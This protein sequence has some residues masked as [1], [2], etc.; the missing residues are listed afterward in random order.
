ML[1]D[2]FDRLSAIYSAGG[3][4]TEEPTIAAM[5]DQAMAEHKLGAEPET[6]GSLLI[7]VGQRVNNA[8][9]RHQPLEWLAEMGVDLRLWGR[10][11]E[12]HPTL[13]R[14]ARGPADNQTQLTAIYQASK[15][16]L[17]MSPHGAVHQRIFEGLSAGGFFLL[18]HSPGD[19]LERHFRK[20]LGWC[21]ANGVI[22][23]PE[24]IRCATPHIRRE[25]AAIAQSL[26]TDPFRLGHSLMDVLHASEQS[27]YI[28]SAGTIWGSD[29]DAVSF[30][31]REELARKVQ[32]FLT[33]TADREQTADRMR[34]PVLERFTY[35]AIS[36]RLLEFIAN[37]LHRSNG[38][39]VAA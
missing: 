8:L 2:I 39:R 14:F 7:F 21:D 34:R 28:R 3:Y 5:I 1:H 17:H 19:E 24:L 18:R 15:I 10:G 23:D 16:N 25:M 11:W 6:K 13:S 32:H 29:Y 36:R 31:N 27:G 30:T 33:D 35:T 38:E 22:S 4:V 26:Q 12:S 20:V 37:D 9:F